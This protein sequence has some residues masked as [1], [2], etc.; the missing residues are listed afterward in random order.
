MKQQALEFSQYL[1]GVIGFAAQATKGAWQDGTNENSPGDMYDMFTGELTAMEDRARE[2]R[3]TLPNVMG[4]AGREVSNTFNNTNITTTSSDE[5]PAQVN[6]FYFEDVVVDDEER[7]ERIVEFIA[8]RINW[9]NTTAGR[10][11]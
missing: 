9:N 3:K 8:R 5:V 7:M 4:D 2:T 10:T 11:V 6:N 1:P